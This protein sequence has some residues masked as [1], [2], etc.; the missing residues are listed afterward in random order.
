MS[1]KVIDSHPV[2]SVWLD[3]R[4]SN[5]KKLYPVKLRAT[6]QIIK[7]GKKAWVQKPYPL[8]KFCSKTDFK[9]ILSTP[10]TTKQKEI[11]NVIIAAQQ[12]ANKILESHTTVNIELFDRLYTSAGNLE[13]VSSVFYI[14]ISELEKEGRVGT[15]DLYRA[16]KNSLP[17]GLSFYEITVPWIRQY[18]KGRNLTTA[19]IYL[20]HLRAIFNKAIDM[21]LVNSDLYP[22]SRS[23]YVI[24][25]TK[26]RKIALSEADKNRLLLISDPGL[27]WCIDMWLASY[28]CYGLNMTDICGLKLKDLKDDIIIINRAKTGNELIIPLKSEVKEII[29]RHG[30][31]TLNPNDYVFPV[32][33]EG[34]TARQMKNRIKDFTKAVNAGLKK[35]QEKLELKIKLT[36]YTARHT[37]AMMALRKGASLELIQE[38][39]GHGSKMTTEDYMSGF[40]LDRKRAISDKL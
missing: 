4:R 14:K 39:L 24:K 15:A 8:K 1:I 34:L 18:V 7:K 5:K 36:T 3:I 30:N 22:F 38:M 11:K 27:R 28:F 29:A 2:I 13:L 21:K 6:F 16:V 40:D 17:E 26:S 9:S 20:R 19:A 10:R 25:K 23:G 35:V 33:R 12:K 37:S 31:R 32:L